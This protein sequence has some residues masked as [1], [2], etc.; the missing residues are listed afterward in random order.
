MVKEA[1]TSKRRPRDQR[2]PSH[3]VLRRSRIDS[4]GCYTK[5]SIKEGELIVEY[6]GPRLKVKMAETLYDDD[7]R[8]YLFG[9]D[10]GKEV[11]DGVGVAA[12]INHS[13]DPNCETDEVNGRIIIRAI[14]DIGRGEEL[15]YDYNLYDGSP[16]DEARC[17][18]SSKNCRGSMYSEDELKRRAKAQKQRAEKAR[19]NCNSGGQ[20]R[21]TATRS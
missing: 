10:G 15:T 1:R 18:C 5:V 4:V 6:T 19:K 21:R 7:P 9:L 8:T 13:C 12:F 2:V 11:I 16:E 17:L 3:L 14:R 20:R